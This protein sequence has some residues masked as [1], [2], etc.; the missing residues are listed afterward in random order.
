[1]NC[2]WCSATSSG[3]CY[4]HLEQRLQRDAVIRRWVVSTLKLMGLALAVWLVWKWGV[5]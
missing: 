4:T 1:M 3:L 5:W 2:R